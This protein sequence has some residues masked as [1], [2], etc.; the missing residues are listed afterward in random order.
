MLNK[1]NAKKL[2]AFNTLS[3]F[4][5]ISFW[6]NWAKNWGLRLLP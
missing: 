6:C 3:G 1:P 4:S 2:K 5:N